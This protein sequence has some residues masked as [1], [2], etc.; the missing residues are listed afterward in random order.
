MLTHKRS[1][2]FMACATTILL[3]IPTFALLTN[4]QW[5]P[6]TQQNKSLYWLYLVTESG[7][8]PMV[9][10]TC[11][12]LT[13]IPLVYLKP[14]VRNSL[15]LVLLMAANI[16]IGQIIK[17]GLKNTFQESRP[18]VSW[19]QQTNDIT[20]HDFYDLPREQRT[21]FI[22][23][24]DFSAYNISSW[25]QLHWS[26][27]TGYSFPSGHSIFVAQWLL[28][29]VL[30]LWPRGFYTPVIVIGIWAMLIQASRLA[31]GMHWPVDIII[32][33]LLANFIV[34]P[35]YL[36]WQRLTKITA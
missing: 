27:E 9:F 35:I 3:I 21:Q 17:S 32:S 24:Q 23:K 29:Y 1:F 5:Y 16:G 34:Y 7:T 4:W 10:G 20:A 19:L 22:L 6:D 25:Q 15:L 30:L 26:K 11:V 13:I 12:V 18:Y 31:L 36:F 8:L 14:S 28:F 33:S 2:A